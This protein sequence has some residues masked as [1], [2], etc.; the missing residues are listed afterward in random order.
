[1]SQSI[2]SPLWSARVGAEDSFSVAITCLG[3]RRKGGGGPWTRALLPLRWWWSLS[4]VAAAVAGGGGEAT[5]QSPLL[6]AVLFA[7]IE[8]IG[9]RAP[10]V[11]N[12]WA[13]ISILLL[14]GALLTIIGIRDSRA[15]TYH[16][17]PLVR[18]IITLITYAH[19]SAGTH[20]GVTDH[21]LAIT[22][23]TQSSDGNT[24][25]LAAENQ[26]RMMFSHSSSASRPPE[27]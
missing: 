21:T 14:D 18:A 19:Q 13:T 23:F 17:A 3:K 12:L 2:N 8:E 24:S 26:I 20:V 6:E 7:F 10:Q 22:F 5:Q 16:T 27:T 11:D 15:S 25:L 9:L 1:M 4:F